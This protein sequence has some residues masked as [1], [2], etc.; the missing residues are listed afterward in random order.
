LLL[1]TG[2]RSETKIKWLSLPE[3]KAVIGDE[4]VAAGRFRELITMCGRLSSINP[5]LMPDEVNVALQRFMKEEQPV[6]KYMK[7][8]VVDDVGRAYGLG[9]RKS[10]T[11]RAWIVKGEGDMLVNGKSLSQYFSRIHQRESAIYA[12]SVTERVGN[13]NVFGVVQ[14]GGNTGQAEALTLAVAKA[15]LVY[16]P[17]LKERL[18]FGKSLDTYRRC[19]DKRANIEYSRL[20]HA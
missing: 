15:L 9:R 7:K 16:E 19:D 8:H 13:Y 17:S 10:A 6:V 20:S 1:P 5:H 11:A 3:Y 2:G 18:R 14:G 12:L 4:P